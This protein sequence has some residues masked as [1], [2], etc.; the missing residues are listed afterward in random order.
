M[1]KA[2]FLLRD[3]VV[4]LNHGSFGACP[5]E[6]FA[7]YQQWQLRLEQQPVLFLGREHTKLL[8]EARAALAAYLHAA[9]DDLVFVPNSTHGVNIVAH[10]L[11]FEVGDEILATNHEYGACNRMWEMLCSQ[12]GAVY[13]QQPLPLPCSSQ[14]ELIEHF[15]RGV[16]PRTK[17]IFISHV[18]SATALHLPVEAIC[19]RAREAG[20]LTLID[21]SH[22]PSLLDI[23]LPAL[24][25]DFY[26]GNCHKW[27]CA[28]KGAGFL[29]VQREHQHRLQPLVISWGNR[30][31]IVTGNHF[32][33][34]FTWTGTAD[35]AAYLTVPEAIAFQQRNNWH[36]QR[37]RCRAL[38][39]ETKQR[40][41]A[42]PGVHSL[43]PDNSNLYLQFFSVALPPCDIVRLKQRLYD[44]YAIEVVVNSWEDVSLLR[45]SVQV[46]NTPED[47]DALLH[48]L[49]VLLPQCVL[50]EN[51]MH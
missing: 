41:C 16:T 1:T 23:D 44:E 27:L 49:E 33:D 20:I 15:W 26:T 39:T 19:Q 29:Y 28:P 51:S 48:A 47:M 32:L 11:H 45:V 3:D 2:D 31:N 4:F 30:G 22:G 10:S 25:A 21:G 14:E 6:V 8:A 40:L 37:A 46:Y 35:P 13:K 12:S 42:L 36:D 18:T 24:G 5:R 50:Q 7:V 9:P 34:E 38:A 43:Y 17:L